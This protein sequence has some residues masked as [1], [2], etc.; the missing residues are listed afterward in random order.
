MTGIQVDNAT[1]Q[2]FY[3]GDIGISTHS[4]VFSV[5]YAVNKVGV[6]IFLLGAVQILLKAR[7]YIEVHFNVII[8]PPGIKYLDILVI[9][10]I[11][12]AN[13]EEKQEGIRPGF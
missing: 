3:L 6:G 12:L 7:N 11:V 8:S 10:Y 9:V 4:E 13:S 1:G 2:V 5:Y